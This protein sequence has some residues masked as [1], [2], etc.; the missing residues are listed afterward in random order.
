MVAEAYAKSV[1]AANVTEMVKEIKTR[2]AY[3]I[4]PGNR[5]LLSVDVLHRL[6]HR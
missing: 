2:P 3:L 1:K 6:R 4:A 5:E